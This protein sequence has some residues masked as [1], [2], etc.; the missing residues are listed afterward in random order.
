MNFELEMLVTFLQSKIEEWH[1]QQRCLEESKCKIRF[2]LVSDSNKNVVCHV[3]TTPIN[4]P[5]LDT[6]NTELLNL[7]FYPSGMKILPLLKL[8]VK[9]H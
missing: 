7:Y 6:C 4:S 3:L 5:I 8:V 2:I 1:Q 9:L